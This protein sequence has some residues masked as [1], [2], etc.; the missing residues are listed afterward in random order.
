MDKLL[1]LIAEEQRHALCT[2]RASEGPAA[3]GHALAFCPAPWPDTLNAAVQRAAQQALRHAARSGAEVENFWSL[4]E[5]A[6]LNLPA[7]M[8]TSMLPVWQETIEALELRTEDWRAR[9]AVTGYRRQLDL[10]ERRLQF[11]K[12]IPL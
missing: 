1:P 12:E 4:T 6:A 2:E 10:I 7:K 8:L 3:L 9:S 11:D 5:H